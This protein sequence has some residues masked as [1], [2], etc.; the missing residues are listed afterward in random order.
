VIFAELTLREIRQWCR[1]GGGVA[2]SSAWRHGQREIG[3]A[4]T[5]RRLAFCQINFIIQRLACFRQ[6]N[7][8]GGA[9]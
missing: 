9:K 5:E 8:A 6:M 3:I 4:A 1:A 7:Q 2:M